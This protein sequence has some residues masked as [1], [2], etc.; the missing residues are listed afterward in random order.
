MGAK[1]SKSSQKKSEKNV[2]G[3]SLKIDSI[4]FKEYGGRPEE[5]VL[6]NATF[7]KINLLVGK[8]SSGKSRLLNVIAGLA[9]MIT[10][11]QPKVF[12]TGEYDVHLSTDDGK[13][14][15]IY[16]VRFENS[17]VVFES[18]LENG[19]KKLDR[20]KDGK[21]K[22]WAE[23]NSIFMEFDAPV[24]QLA[25]KYR[26]D[27]I[28][29]PFFEQLN[30]WASNLRHY[31]FGTNFGRDRLMS[32]SQF[33]EAQKIEE[34][35][36]DTN[37]VIRLYAKAYNKYTTRFDK[38][39]LDDLALLGYDCTEVGADFLQLPSLPSSFLTLYVQEK[40]LKARTNQ[41]NMSQGMFRALSLVIH[42]NYCVIM[43]EPRTLLIDDIGE[44][45]DFDRAKKFVSLLIKKAKKNNLQLIMTSND[46]FIMNGVPLIHWGIVNRKKNKVDL[47][48]I[49][50]SKKIFDEFQDLGLNNF[51]FFATN[52][53]EDGLK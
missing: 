30:N 1:T 11:A 28:Q 3:N 35:V 37:E 42:L 19:N 15:Y 18:L 32:A 23:K 36:R 53:F 2:L 51:D 27:K 10:G 7:E 41:L 34:E 40:D 13:F 26:K 46:R 20:R 14:K 17:G 33:Q 39:I 47:I 8:N 4:T 31:H 50:N 48:N 9:N 21:S 16:T 12:E 52:F 44:G 5:W 38:L 49:R 6:N 43:K 29:H 25:V 24:E 45:L 22:I